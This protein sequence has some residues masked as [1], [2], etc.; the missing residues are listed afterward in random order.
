MKKSCFAIVVVFACIGLSAADA[1]VVSNV[2]VNPMRAIAYRPQEVSG[3]N[4]DALIWMMQAKDVS[5][6]GNRILG[7]GDL[8]KQIIITNGAVSGTGF[9]DGVTR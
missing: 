8:L 1:A 4:Y 2:F 9:T 6:I 5:F 7:A 3:I